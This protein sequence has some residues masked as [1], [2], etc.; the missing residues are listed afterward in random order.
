MSRGYS[1]LRRWLRRYGT[2]DRVRLALS[3]WWDNQQVVWLAE[4]TRPR[5]PLDLVFVRRYV[6]AQMAEIAWPYRHPPKAND[7]GDGKA[8]T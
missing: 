6:Q 8:G 1:P 3:G 5:K 2:P 7:P 4:A